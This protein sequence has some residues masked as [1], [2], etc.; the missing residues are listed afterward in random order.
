M[1]PRLAR[2]PNIT[3]I[4]GPVRIRAQTSRRTTQGGVAITRRNASDPPATALTRAEH[5]AADEGP[6]SE[7]VL[8]VQ[9]LMRE[10][11]A[12]RNSRPGPL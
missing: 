8:E 6:G 12:D 7:P 5:D 4:G 3:S 11:P 2:Q 10:Q 9:H 1:S